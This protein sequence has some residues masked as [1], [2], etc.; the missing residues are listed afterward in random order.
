MPQRQ[1][2]LAV[3]SHRNIVKPGAFVSTI[4]GHAARNP[5]TWPKHIHFGPAQARPGRLR[6]VPGLAR[7]VNRVRAWAVTPARGL[8]R[9][10]TEL[11]ARPDI[12]P[13]TPQ[14]T[15]QPASP[16]TIGHN[17]QRPLG[18][19]TPNPSPRAYPVRTARARHP[20]RGSAPRRTG[21]TPAPM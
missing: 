15:A 18:L 5:L 12:G 9:L 2:I 14:I 3:D 1:R 11:A 7:L 6:T 21:R 4:V 19:H 16:Q 10:S 20:V 17:G 8:A 13:L